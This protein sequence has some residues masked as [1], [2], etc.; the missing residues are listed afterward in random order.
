MS[1]RVMCTYTH[2]NQLEGLGRAL[3]TSKTKK[4]TSGEALLAPFVLTEHT[5]V[6]FEIFE[7]TVPYT[8]QG[9]VRKTRGTQCTIINGTHA[10]ALIVVK[11]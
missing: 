11:A 3:V 2:G 10:H 7:W 6:S 4:V 9:Q 8:R 1:G 5:L